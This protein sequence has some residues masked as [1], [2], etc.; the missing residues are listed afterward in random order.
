MLALRRT[1]PGAQPRTASDRS[2]SS[3]EIKIKIYVTEHAY[4]PE[5]FTDNPRKWLLD[6]I[7]T[8]CDS[9][10]TFYLQTFLNNG[11]KTNIIVVILD[12][13]N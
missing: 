1:R 2:A 10:S 4:I 11:A 7:E 9:K 6:P 8:I 12:I 13:F 5:R 3:N